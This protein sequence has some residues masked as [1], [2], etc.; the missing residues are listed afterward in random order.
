V[1]GVALDIQS[2]EELSERFRDIQEAVAKNAPGARI[3]G[4]G[5]QRMVKDLDYEL[6]LGSRT[7]TEFGAHILF[8]MGGVAAEIFQEFAIGLPPLNQTLARRLVDETKVNS[9]LSGVRG[10]RPADVMQLEQIIV[11][12]ANLVADFPEIREI[13]L[14]PIG[15]SNGEIAALDARIVIE[16]NCLEDQVSPYPHLVITPYP[17]RYVTPFT[18]TNGDGVL[19]RPIRPEDEPLE[20]EMLATLSPETVRGRF[21]QSIKNISHEELTRFCNIDYEREMAFVAELRQGTGRRIIGVSRIIMESDLGAGEFAV[22]VHDDYQNKGLGYELLDMLVGVAEERRLRK[23]YG[24]VLSDNS[25]MLNM[26]QKSG[27]IL[28]SSR[29]GLTRVELILR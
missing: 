5:V 24:V 9:M 19:L 6:I 28:G 21:F 8:G 1:G 18:L 25:R 27:F 7:D 22:L 20:Y 23:I 17:S 4:M 2:P 11:S 15:I 3:M 29:E 16:P 26:C 14:N 12:F 13:D 10:K